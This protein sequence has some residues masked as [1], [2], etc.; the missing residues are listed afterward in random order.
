M[1][2]VEQVFTHCEKRFHLLNNAVF[3]QDKADGDPQ[4]SPG[5][6][7]EPSTQSEAHGWAM[8]LRKSARRL[9]EIGKGLP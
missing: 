8:M 9:E 5:L 1:A 3:M 6:W 2:W 7:L 4:G